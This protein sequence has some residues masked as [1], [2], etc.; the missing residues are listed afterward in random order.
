MKLNLWILSALLLLAQS[1]AAQSPR[2]ETTADPDR[3]GGFYHCYPACP[4]EPTPAP[5][6]YKPF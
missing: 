4:S 1:A 6:G 5:E 3:M 2:E